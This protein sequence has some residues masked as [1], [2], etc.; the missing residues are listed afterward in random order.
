MAA[1]SCRYLPGAPGGLDGRRRDGEAHLGAHARQGQPLGGELHQPAGPH[2]P[3][4]V[5]RRGHQPWT[6]H[7]VGHWYGQH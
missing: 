4:R 1:S 3:A 2:R 7:L 6:I 5:P